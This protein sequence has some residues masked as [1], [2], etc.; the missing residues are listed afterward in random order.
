MRTKVFLVDDHELFRQG[1]RALL[2]IPEIEIVGEAGNGQE[3]L[4]RL[5]SVCPDILLLD[6]NMSIMNGIDC[7]RKIKE[8]FPEVKILALSMQ[9]AES[10]LIEMIGAGAKGYILKT[11]PKDELLYAIKRISNGGMFVSSEFI[12]NKVN[13]IKSASE[14]RSNLT[15]DLKITD[16]EL[17]VLKLIVKGY[18]N[19]QIADQLFASVRT[20]ETRRK[21]LLDKTKATNTATLIHF[22][23]TNGLV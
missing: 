11:S 10:D 13:H 9:D 21:R 12:L 14:N 4:E 20:I 5:Q 3:T 23:M 2:D 19:S 1:I 22:A 15:A 18:T 6:I 7:A 8:E 17:E 16:R